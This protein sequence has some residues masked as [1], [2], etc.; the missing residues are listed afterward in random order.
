MIFEQY[1]HVI[2]S[3]QWMRTKIKTKLSNQIGKLDVEPC[4]IF[5]LGCVLNSFWKELVVIF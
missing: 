1:Y 4:L 3:S 2:N 5:C